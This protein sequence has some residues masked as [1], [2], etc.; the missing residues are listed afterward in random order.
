[1]I[2]VPGRTCHRSLALTNSGQMVEVEEILF[3]SVERHCREVGIRRGAVLKCRAQK[4]D[5][6]EVTLPSG[7]GA[8]LP[9][10]YAWFVAVKPLE[11]SRAETM[12]S[13]SRKR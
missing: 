11:R 13:T 3:D 8:Q 10:H 9:R 12:R 4:D 5:E 6:V 2:D 7:G 1:M